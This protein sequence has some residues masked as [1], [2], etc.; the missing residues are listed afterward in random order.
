[1]V[2]SKVGAT[3]QC[4]SSGQLGAGAPRRHALCPKQLTCSRRRRSSWDSVLFKSS[5]TK[6]MATGQGREAGSR[7]VAIRLWCMGWQ[8]R[9]AQVDAAAPADKTAQQLTRIGPRSF[10]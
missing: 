10:L 2:L 3:T 6:R 9:H 7:D 1:M 8:R 5:S 4:N